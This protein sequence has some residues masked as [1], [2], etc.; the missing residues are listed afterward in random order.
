MLQIFHLNLELL[1][2]WSVF[3]FKT[4]FL[5][6]GV[7]VCWAERVAWQLLSW[8]RAVCSWNRAFSW[9][10][11]SCSQLKQLFSV[12]T[13]LFAV[14]TELFSVETELFSVSKP[15]LPSRPN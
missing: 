12:E 8:N 13:E 10:K 14:E 9:L 2:L 5:E 15:A 3:Y 1:D 7:K 6:L 11:Q 4:A